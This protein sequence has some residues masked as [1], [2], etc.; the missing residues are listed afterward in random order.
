MLLL[1]SLDLPQKGKQPGHNH[2]IQFNPSMLL[3]LT[4][5][6]CAKKPWRNIFV[7]VVYKNRIRPDYVGNRG[8]SMILPLHK[9]KKAIFQAVNKWLEWWKPQNN[10]RSDCDEPNPTRI[11]TTNNSQI[12]G[13]YQFTLTNY[14]H[15]WFHFICFAG[16]T[17]SILSNAPSIWQINVFF[18]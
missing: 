6:I 16:W 7:V 3:L 5:V 13:I 11:I 17:I 2:P 14:S 18:C 9:Q 12:D 4:R 10:Q 8:C 15:R 1:G